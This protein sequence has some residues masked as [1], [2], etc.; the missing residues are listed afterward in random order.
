MIDVD[1]DPD[2]SLWTRTVAAV[3]LPGVDPSI[4][5]SL[6]DPAWSKLLATVRQHRLVGLLHAA[7]VELPLSPTRRAEVRRL[8]APEV[9]WQLTLE[10]HAAGLARLFERTGV[11]FLLLKGFA[12]ADRYPDRSWRPFADLDVLVAPESYDAAHE[13][14]RAVGAARR[15]TSLGPVFDRRYGKSI[16]HRM[17]GGYEVDAHRTLVIGSFGLSVDVPSLFSSAGSVEVRGTLVPA[18]AAA[19]L[20]VHAAYTAVLS[21]P[22]RLRSL[23]DVVQVLAACDDG[24]AVVDAALRWRAGIVLRE[25][26]LAARSEI[27]PHL[28]APIVEWA[29]GYRPSRS[30]ERWLRPYRVPGGDTRAQALG[31]WRALG[32]ARLRLDYLRLVA[33]GALRHRVAP[34]VDG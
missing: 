7:A 6:T 8:H 5:P 20:A 33:V 2:L 3:G 21:I 19:D 32:S 26:I 22:F 4:L 16:T 14:L 9:A 13:A 30:E 28:A 24:D 25:A 10:E 17:P 27:G 31:G 18:L 12:L 34:N 1:G 29:E 15:G 11:R 23:R